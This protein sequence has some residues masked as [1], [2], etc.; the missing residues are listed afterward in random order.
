[1]GWLDVCCL[2]RYYIQKKKKGIQVMELPVFIFGTQS[3]RH[4]FVVVIRHI[5][6]YRDR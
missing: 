5:F 2:F 4:T 1:M 3:T 6:I